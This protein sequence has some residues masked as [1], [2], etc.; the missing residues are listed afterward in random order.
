MKIETKYHGP[1]DINEE[2]LYTFSSGLP[3]FPDEK[4]FVILPLE[5]TP[6]YVLQSVQAAQ[7][8][9]VLANPFDSFPDY[10]VKLSD[11]VLASLK[12]EKEE[13]VAVY[14]ILTV[15]EPFAETTANLQAPV[16]INTSSRLA[17]Q[18]ITN[19]ASFSMRQR[20][21]PEQEGK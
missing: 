11:D 15:R 8:A 7:T 3:G 6:L 10:R 18:Y 21:I 2:E 9:F 13:D 14:T 19:D 1:L 5:N 16:V 20:L 17:K 4:Q 12:I